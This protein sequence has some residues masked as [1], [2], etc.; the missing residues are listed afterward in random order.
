MQDLTALTYDRMQAES[1]SVSE[2]EQTDCNFV[3]DLSQNDGCFVKVYPERISETFC[4]RCSRGLRDV[5]LTNWHTSSPCRS[6]SEMFGLEGIAVATAGSLLASL[7][8]SVG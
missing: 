1:G 8:R 4:G 6:T 2:V 7:H 5:S 3:L